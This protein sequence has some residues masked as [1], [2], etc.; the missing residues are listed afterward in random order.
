MM[1]EQSMNEHIIKIV[2]ICVVGNQNSVALA[3]P[4]SSVFVGPKLCQPF[5]PPKIIPAST[6]FLL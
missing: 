2:Y 5:S 1:E 3:K 4:G 6:F